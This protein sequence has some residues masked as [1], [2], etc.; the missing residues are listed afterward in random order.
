MLSSICVAVICRNKNKILGEGG[1]AGRHVGLKQEWH[2]GQDRGRR[3]ETKGN[4][5]VMRAKVSYTPTQHRVFHTLKKQQSVGQ[6]GQSTHCVCVPWVGLLSS[7]VG[8]STYHKL[9]SDVGLGDEH[10]LS[11]SNLL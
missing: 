7:T 8:V 9:A 11:Q 6:S 3:P 10:L 4:P 2:L 1:G 5:T